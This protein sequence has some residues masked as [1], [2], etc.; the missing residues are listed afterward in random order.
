MVGKPFLD[1]LGDLLRRAGDG[2]MSEGAGKVTEQLPQCRPVSP[3][4]VQDHLGPA[5][6]RLDQ[7]GVREILRPEWAVQWQ[8]LETMPAEPAGEALAPNP[9][10]AQ[11]VDLARQAL[12]LG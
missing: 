8:V 11:I 6:C 2:E 7:A 5:A 4:Q 3:H 9:R 12:R 10:I 1:Q